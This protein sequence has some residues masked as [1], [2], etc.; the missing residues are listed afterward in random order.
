[1]KKHK[2]LFLLFLF[3]GEVY[4]KIEVLFTPKDDV[5]GK[6]I[7][8]FKSANKR[9][10]IAIY[11]FT[12]K[13][14]ADALIKVQQEKPSLEVLVVV[15]SISVTSPFGKAKYLN[16]NGISVLVYPPAKS[17]ASVPLKNM[18]DQKPLYWRPASIMHNKY[19]IIDDFLQTGS[20]N[21]TVSA[22]NLNWENSVFCDEDSL[23]EKF[24]ENFL[25]LKE[26]C[27]S[28]DSFLKAREESFVKGEAAKEEKALLKVT[29]VEKEEK[30]LRYL[31]GSF[32]EKGKSFVQSV[33]A[34]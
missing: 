32:W 20:F 4:S 23:V 10:L 1:M 33:F 5:T 8:R 18:S 21:L 31:A 26:K 6:T 14:I 11:M 17:K 22:N 24:L 15:D 19:A 12:D 28:V 13:R 29:R 7:A 30:G 27:V 25:E 16:N 2:L 34:T 9:I 3:F